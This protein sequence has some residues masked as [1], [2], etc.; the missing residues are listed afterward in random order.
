MSISELRD[1]ATN[2]GINIKGIRKKEE[3]KNLILDK[4]S[5]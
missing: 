2:M 1:K 3:I 5:D 4:L